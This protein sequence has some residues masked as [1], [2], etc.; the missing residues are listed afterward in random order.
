MKDDYG[1]ALIEQRKERVK[2]GHTEIL[3]MDIG[4]QLDTI[5]L[6]RVEA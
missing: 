6:Q 5:C 4:R 3:T 2:F 1:S